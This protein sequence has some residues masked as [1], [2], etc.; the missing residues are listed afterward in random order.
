MRM[1]CVWYA[2]RLELFE[3]LNHMAPFGR[4]SLDFAFKL[5][6]KLFSS[7]GWQHIERII[8]EDA[9]TEEFRVR[10]T[11]DCCDDDEEKEPDDEDRAYAPD[12][13]RRASKLNSSTAVLNNGLM[14]P[15]RVCLKP[16]ML[17]LCEL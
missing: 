4:I 8:S 9:T 13:R 11:A 1:V 2:E 17:L 12:D 16:G 10:T 7:F 5:A 15:Y 14:F 3:L 6:A